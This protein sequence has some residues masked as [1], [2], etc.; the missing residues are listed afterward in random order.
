[1]RGSQM[2]WFKRRPRCSGDLYEETD[3]YGC[4]VTCMQCSFSKDVFEKLGDPGSISVDPVPA[5]A[6][7]KFQ[8]GKR[9]RLSH[10][11][12]HFS[13]TF[14]RGDYSDFRNIA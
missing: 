5:P 12:R 4:F 10:G 8:G 9:R 3:Q 7:P 13:R 6:V 14:N 2:F 1:M 11:G